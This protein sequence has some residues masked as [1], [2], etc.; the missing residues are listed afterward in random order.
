MDG[1][2]FT[3]KLKKIKAEV[4]AMKQAHKYGLNRTDFDYIYRKYPISARAISY[5]LVITFETPNI[6]QPY[7]SI[8]SEGMYMYSGFAWESETKKLRIT[9]TYVAP[10]YSPT[11]YDAEIAIVSTS[12]ITSMEWEELDRDGF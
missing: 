11:G 3:I 2:D 10:E 1:T 9:G 4:L 8:Q 6:E 12:P 5:R 7:I